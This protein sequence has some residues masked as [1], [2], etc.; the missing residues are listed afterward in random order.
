MRAKRPA[1]QTVSASDVRGTFGQLIERVSKEEARVVIEDNGDPVAAIVPLADLE[2]LGWWKS[3]NGGDFSILDEM[4][5]AFKDVPD[6]V[7]RREVTKAVSA[8]R[9]ELRREVAAS[10]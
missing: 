9:R 7:L 8:A 6:S 1:I 2:Q 4:R 5:A 10:S 3:D